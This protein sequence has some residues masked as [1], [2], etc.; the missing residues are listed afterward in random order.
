M[1]AINKGVYAVILEDHTPPNYL[2]QYS[3]NASAGL[4]SSFTS[5]LLAYLI[6]LPVGL[7]AAS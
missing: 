3:G 7:R 1:A 5:V 6:G 2:Y 4:C